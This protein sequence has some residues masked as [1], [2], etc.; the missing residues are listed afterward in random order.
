MLDLLFLT[1]PSI[2]LAFYAT[3]AHCWLIINLLSIRSPRSF[4]ADLLSNRSVL[5]MYW[6][7]WLFLPRCMTTLSLVEL[8]QVPLCLT[9]QPVQVSLN[10]S[11]AF[12][13]V[14]HSFQLYI[15]SKIAEGGLYPF[16]QVSE[17]VGQ[18]WAQYQCLGNAAS[19]RSPTGLC[20]A[21]HS[22]LS[23]ASWPG[24]SQP[25]CHPHHGDLQ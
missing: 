23:N 9:L 13:C 22:P 16:I 4:S 1:H 6:C 18:D 8:H 2:P 12:W 24:L 25:H 14:S 11:T 7:M 17:D 20:T 10:G 21:D 3:R 15:I 19:Y 5:N